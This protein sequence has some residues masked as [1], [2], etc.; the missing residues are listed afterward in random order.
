MPTPDKFASVVPVEDDLVHTDR[1]PF[2]FDIRRS[3]HEDE[4]LITPIQ[5]AVLSG[6]MTPD[7]ATNFVAGKLL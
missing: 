4:R 3:C 2:C 1:Y 6:L 7:E 5:Q